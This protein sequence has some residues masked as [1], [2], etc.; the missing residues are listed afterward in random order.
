MRPALVALAAALAL[1]AA[2]AAH[3]TIAPPFVEAGVETEIGMTVPNERPPHATLAVEVTM[4]TGVSIVS[5]TAPEGWT[6]TVDGGT[7][8]WSGGQIA[9]RTGVVFPVRIEASVSPG[10][11]EIAARQ[12]YDDGAVVRWTSDLIVLPASG[13][14][15]SDE[16]PWPAVAAAAVVLAVVAG[17]LLLLRRLRR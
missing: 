12:R 14:A 5:P 8:I 10:T 17:S 16:R 3:V 11:Y 9:N 7:V 15:T 4:P 1:P 2:A 6:A 13:E